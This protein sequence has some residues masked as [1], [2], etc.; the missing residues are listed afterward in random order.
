MLTAS[1]M[2]FLP[3]VFPDRIGCRLPRG[4][5]GLWGNS[6][7]PS[8]SEA[9]VPPPLGHDLEHPQGGQDAVSRR[10]VVEEDRVARLLPAQIRPPGDHLFMDVLVADLRPEE[11]E[12]ARFEGPFA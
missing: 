8:T 9:S 5:P 2:S 10:E 12:A 11:P 7:R 1:L 3:E 4:L 6:T